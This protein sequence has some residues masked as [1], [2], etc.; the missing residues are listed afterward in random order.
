MNVE[1]LNP[2]LTDVEIQ[3]HRL[4][5]QVRALDNRIRRLENK[6]NKVYTIDLSNYQ[7]FK[8]DRNDGK[9]YCMLCKHGENKSPEKNRTNISYVECMLNPEKP[10]YKLITDS[11]EKAERRE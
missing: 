1:H 6:Q 10:A 5:S 8:P 11:C 2:E 3:L 9:L 4:R 7:G